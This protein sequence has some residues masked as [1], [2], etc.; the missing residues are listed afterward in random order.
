MYDWLV[1]AFNKKY[2]N[3]KV[4]F[5]HGSN[6]ENA[7]YLEHAMNVPVDLMSGMVSGTAGDVIDLKNQPY[8]KYGENRLPEDLYPYIENDLEIYKEDF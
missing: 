2:P 6:S 4:I 8:V 1:Q 3:V 5:S 7:L